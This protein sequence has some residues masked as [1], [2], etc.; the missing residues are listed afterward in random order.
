MFGAI[1]RKQFEKLPVIRPDL[2]L[3]A[4]FERIAGPMDQKIRQATLEQRSLAETRDY[5]LPRLMSGTVRV[6]RESE[7]A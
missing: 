3:I 1:N 2:A 5:L 6:A 7:A 4:E